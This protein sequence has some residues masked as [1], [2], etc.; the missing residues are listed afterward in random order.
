MNVGRQQTHNLPVF[1]PEIFFELPVDVEVSTVAVL[2]IASNR[3]IIVDRID[4]MPVTEEF[5][6]GRNV[7]L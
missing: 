2:D 1:D 7:I 6:S 5:D 3:G 4:L